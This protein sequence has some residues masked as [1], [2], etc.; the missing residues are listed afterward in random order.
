MK[1]YIPPRERLKTDL[2][3][4]FVS[5]VCAVVL[6]SNGTLEHIVNATPE[7]SVITTFIA[8]I[9][10]TSVFTIAPASALFVEIIGH[11]G[12]LLTAIVGAAGALL[13]DLVLI[14]FIRDHVSKDFAYLLRKAKN[15]RLWEIFHLRSLRFLSPIIGALVIASPLPDE[16]GVAMLG[17]SRLPIQYIVIISYAMNVLGIL[18]LGVVA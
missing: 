4:I 16:L 9:F 7:G 1:K 6:Y 13:G 18:I 14:L 15:T 8:G 11:Q 5:V 12:L 2:A 17:A 10:F 3:W